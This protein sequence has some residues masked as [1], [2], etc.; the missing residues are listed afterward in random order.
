MSRSEG[1]DD[2]QEQVGGR[3]FVASRTRPS[4]RWLVVFG[5]LMV[6]ILASASGLTYVG[7]RT[8]RDSRAGKSVSTVNDPSLPGYEALLEPTPT[9][10]VLHSSGS[11]LLSVAVLALA[12]GDAGGSVLLV[13]PD[14]RLASGENAFT[15]AA[16]AAFN[17]SAT[18][19]VPGLQELLGIGLSE[20]AVVD[21]ARWSELVAP[22]APLHLD[23]PDVVGPFAAGALALTAPQ[24]GPYLAARNA[25]ESDLA[26]L[27]RQQL[28]FD[29]WIGAVAASSDPGVVP[30]EGDAGLGRFV[31]GLA[32]GPHRIATLPVVETPT[33][34][35]TRLDA[36]HDAAAALVVGLVPFPTAPHPGGRVRV[37]V[38]DGTG[39]AQHVLKVAPRVVSAAAEIVVIGN[40]DRFT[41]TTTEIRY[42][43]P[44]QRAAAEAIRA[45]L[46]GGRVVADP[47][48]TDAF[49]VTIVLGTDV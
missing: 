14:T 30:G 8:V 19:A 39:K 45:S 5:S 34:A 24:V 17:G 21:D 25:G 32:A 38:L 33:A 7:V 35:G 31:R 4:R 18:A 36:D 46:G 40:A 41:Y 37:R 10:V 20:V 27:Y 22:V 42:H 44:L 13:P 47:R 3:H 6:V 1:D 26:R 2:E 49:D 15:L 23:N 28:L 11:T 16:V 43:D 12:S 29:A 48:P 9:L